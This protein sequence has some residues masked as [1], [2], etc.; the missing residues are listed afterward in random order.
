LKLDGYRCFQAP[1]NVE[2]MSRLGRAM[3]ELR[4]RA[5]AFSSTAA[6]AM[7]GSGALVGVA[8]GVT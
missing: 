1:A 5:G 4:A 3:E 6:E 8:R 2:G 7:F